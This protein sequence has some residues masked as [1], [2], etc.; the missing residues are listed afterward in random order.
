MVMDDRPDRCRACGTIVQA[1]CATDEE[2]CCVVLQACVDGGSHHPQRAQRP[3]GLISVPDCASFKSR[4]AEAATVAIVGVYGP[5]API[6]I[7]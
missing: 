2:G 6:G 5:S 1:A 7:T 3:N 4:R